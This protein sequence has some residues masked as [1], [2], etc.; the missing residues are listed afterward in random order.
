VSTQQ[1]MDAAYGRR[2]GRIVPMPTAARPALGPALLTV[3]EP[4]RPSRVVVIGNLS[5]R[6]SRVRFSGG[7]ELIVPDRLL[8]EVE[9]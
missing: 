9:S 4:H 8:S 2:G 6:R 5:H 7:A 1:R 3:D